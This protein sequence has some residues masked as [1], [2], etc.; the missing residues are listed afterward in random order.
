VDEIF[1][2][3]SQFQ[4]LS[5]THF[6]ELTARLQNY[7]IFKKPKEIP[8]PKMVACHTMP[9]PFS[10]FYCHYQESESKVFKVS[11]GGENEDRADAVAVYH[12]DTSQ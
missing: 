6:I 4:V 10:I 9:C 1:G 11:L 12:L 3:S 5:T 8:A 7:T 2:L